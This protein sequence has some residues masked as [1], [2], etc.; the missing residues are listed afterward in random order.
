MRKFKK[1]VTTV[2]AAVMALSVSACNGGGNNSGGSQ[3]EDP[4][5]TYLDVGVFNAGLGTTYFDEMKKDFEAYYAKTSFEEGK[6]GVILRPFKKSTEFNPVNLVNSMNKLEQVLYILDHGDYEEFTQRGYL[7]DVTDVM[8]EKYLDS[9]GNIAADTGKTAEKTIEDT[10]I[11]GYSDVFKKEGKYY[12]VPYMLSVPGIIYDADLFDES[13]LYF[14]KDGT[15]G[16]NAA[17]VA[18]GQCSAG[19][20]G[21][22]GTSDDG[23]PSTWPEFLTL[24]ERIRVNYTP[25]T[26]AESP[27]TYQL[28]RLVNTIWANYEGYENYMLNYSFNGNDGNLGEITENNL[29]E[30]LNQE[31]RKAAVKAFYDIT[32]NAGNY[33]SKAKPGGGNNHTGAQRE[34]IQSKRFGRRIAMFVENSYWEQ[35]ARDVF[36]KEPSQSVNG[37]GKRN[38]KYMPIPKFTGVEGIESQTNTERVLPAQFADSYICISAKNANKNSAVQTKVAKLF[39]KFIQQRSQ[40]LKYTANTGCIRPYQYTFTA[41][42][43]ATCTPYTQSILTF[44]EEG[45]RLA[46]NLPIATKRRLFNGEIGF[47]EADNG[48]AFRAKVGNSTYMDPFTYFI[49]NDKKTVDDAVNDMKTTITGL[50]KQAG[51]IQ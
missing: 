35:E 9:E 6:E 2:L 4:T 22:L 3:T 27:S 49:K 44:I 28:S 51:A 5:K 16:A 45:A 30:L 24:L 10:M 13:S 40:L 48:F 25:F 31:G 34:Y 36:D 14:K 42:E 15:I 43:K 19:P 29:I 8:T 46:P 39:I 18:A 7:A 38:F 41:E 26:W 32:K 33:S 20:D 47:F 12:A 21:E 11:D 37:Y 17:A 23:L 50:L 1:L